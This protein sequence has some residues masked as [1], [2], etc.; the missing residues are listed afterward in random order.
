VYPYDVLSF[1]GS[2]GKWLGSEVNLRW[3]LRADNRL[4]LG[5]EYKN[6]LKADY[7]NFTADTSFFDS[8]FPFSTFSFYLEDEYQ[9]LERVSLTLGLRHDE[10]PDAGSSTTPR[11][12]L[13]Y[14]PAKST[15]LKL[16][17]G[18]AFRAPNVYELHYESPIDGF[19]SN[20]ALRPEKIKTREFI[21]EQRLGKNVFGI[22]SFYTNDMKNLIDQ[23][24]DPAD[25]MGQFKNVSRA[26][27]RGL[28]I[29]LNSRLP[30]GFRGY[31]NY[32]TQKAEDADTKSKLTNS[33]SHL[34]KLGIIWPVLR[35]FYVS[36][37]LQH[38]TARATVYQTKTDSYLLA[39]LNLAVRPRL[40]SDSP[41][42]SLLNHMRISLLIK[43]VFDV[44]YKTPGGFEH[45]Q[46]GIL[47]NGRNFMMNLQYNF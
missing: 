35:H 13:V 1:D 2:N 44:S 40:E 28:E 17:Y 29:E 18:E 38:E 23:T 45:K 36:G 10:Y 37:E 14:N 27:A 30:G 31:V 6:H 4:I 19:K 21:V 3:D 8:N 39:N 33:P 41:A 24:I 5:S 25:S 34:V 16:L 22:F 43:N 47:Q 15:T 32:A 9:I 12:A 42:A 20:P 46:P 11:G 7:R 26:K